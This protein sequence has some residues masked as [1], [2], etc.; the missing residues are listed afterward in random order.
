MK[1]KLTFIVMALFAMNMTVAHAKQESN[2]VFSGDAKEFITVDGSNDLFGNMNNMMP[3]EM[4]EQR[5]VL[6]ND[7]K[8]TMKFYLQLKVV[9]PLDEGTNNQAI[10]DFSLKNNNEEFYSSKII[11]MKNVNSDNM[12]DHILLAELS[13]GESTIIDFSILLDGDSMDNTYQNKEGELQFIFSVEDED[14][15]PPTIIDRIIET[16]DTGDSTKT[17][18]YIIAGVA[19][20]GVLIVLFKKK[21]RGDNA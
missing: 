16:V 5:V 2:L 4:R 17:V 19:S 11:G 13:K 20:I 10:Y 7:D 8:T 3:G 15:V 14:P 12:D 1:K 21:G 9:T 18:I 6:S